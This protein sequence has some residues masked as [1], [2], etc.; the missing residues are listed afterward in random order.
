MVDKIVQ[1]LDGEVE[2][3]TVAVLGL[4]FKPETDDM[5]DAPA[6]EIIRGLL[7]RGAHVR[8]F[9]PVAMQE[10]ARVLPEITCCKDAYEACENADAAV[11]VTEWNQFRML[12]MERVRGLL[13]R[14]VMVDLRNVYDPEPMRKAGF[15]YVSVGR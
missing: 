8:A 4:S 3:R 6:V 10:A 14:P 7:S 2:G 1:A 12:D 13:R 9:D 5:R 11:I 15:T